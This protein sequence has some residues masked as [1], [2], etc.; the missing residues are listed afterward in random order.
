MVRYERFITWSAR[1]T[2]ALFL[3]VTIA[4]TLAAAADNLI[5]LGWGY[6]WADALL[7]LRVIVGGCLV[8]LASKVVARII[9]FPEP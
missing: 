1:V 3:L 9:G 6:S 2:F 7:G 4:F 5:G 8:Y